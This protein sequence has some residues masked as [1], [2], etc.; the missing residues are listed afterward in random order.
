MALPDRSS[1]ERQR[2][3]MKEEM[4]FQFS[5]GLFIIELDEVSLFSIDIETNFSHGTPMHE[6]R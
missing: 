1:L 5:V 4:V 6:G 2:G 3:M